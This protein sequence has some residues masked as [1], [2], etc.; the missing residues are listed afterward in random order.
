MDGSG[1]AAFWASNTIQYHR[2][3]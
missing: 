1:L 3:V 2:R